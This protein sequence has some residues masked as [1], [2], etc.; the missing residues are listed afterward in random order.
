M[1]PIFGNTAAER[2]IAKALVEC[3]ELLAGDAWSTS[4]WTFQ[5]RIVSSDPPSVVMKAF[6]VM[7]NGSAAQC[8]EKRK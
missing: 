2:K 7:W 3:V 4:A 8:V 6:D 1:R 5:E